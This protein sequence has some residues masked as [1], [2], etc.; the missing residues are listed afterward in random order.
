[1]R[2]A[3]ARTRQQK[4]W[5]QPKDSSASTMAALPD[6]TARCR[7]VRPSPCVASLIAPTAPAVLPHAP[8]ASGSRN[9]ASAGSAWQS[10]GHQDSFQL[11]TYVHAPSTMPAYGELWWPGC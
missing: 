4:P 8:A 10:S 1:M 11:I 6:R 7:S 5:L 2:R 9:A 3:G